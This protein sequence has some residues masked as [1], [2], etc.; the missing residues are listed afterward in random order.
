MNRRSLFAFVG[1]A[2]A[3]IASARFAAAADEPIECV[4]EGDNCNGENKTCCE[5]LVCETTG[6]EN[7]KECQPGITC[8]TDEDCSDGRVCIDG[9]CRVPEP[10]PCESDEDCPE[11]EVCRNG[12]CRRPI[13]PECETDLDCPANAICDDGV[14]RR[15]CTDDGDCTAPAVCRSGI[16]VV[17]TVTN[18]TNVTVPAAQLSIL[19]RRRRR[20]HH[21]RRR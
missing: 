20:K 21:R 8:E 6:G 2:W 4:A 9:F 15:V 5:G 13:P 10:P 7:E 14:C 19:R 3:E 17:I 16:C 11:G 18:T 12:V 1:I